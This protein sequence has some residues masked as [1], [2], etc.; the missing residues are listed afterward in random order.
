MSF[1]KVPEWTTWT[2]LGLLVLWDLV[3][4][5]CPFGPLRLLVESSQRLNQPIPALLYSATL[6]VELMADMNHD[7]V[8]YTIDSKPNDNS[9]RCISSTIPLVNNRSGS[10]LREVSDDTPLDSPYESNPQ[11]AS[12]ITTINHTSTPIED[13]SD[14]NK[15]RPGLKLGLGDFVFYSLLMGRAGKKSVYFRVFLSGIQ[16]IDDCLDFIRSMMIIIVFHL[17]FPIFL[18]SIR[19]ASNRD[20]PF[21][22]L[23]F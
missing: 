18:L 7:S 11:V 8:K 21:F 22:F 15:K 23:S 5:L 16:G 3:A 2:L 17:F 19:Q 4:V 20:F 12:N 6:L 9:Q 10:S 13:A 14:I 1:I